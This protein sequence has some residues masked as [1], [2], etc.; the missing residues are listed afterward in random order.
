ML[1]G[2]SLWCHGLVCSVGLWYFLILITCFL[3]TRE[4]D[5]YQEKCINRNMCCIMFICDLGSSPHDIV[6]PDAFFTTDM[7]G[8]AISKVTFKNIPSTDI[9]AC[10][11]VMPRSQVNIFLNCRTND[12]YLRNEFNFWNVHGIMNTLGLVQSK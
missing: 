3:P 8:K 6:S 7:T 2:S 4:S 9:V 12:R 5:V 10:F 1:C 11:K